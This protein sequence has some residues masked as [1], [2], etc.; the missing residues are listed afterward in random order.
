MKYKLYGY[1][2]DRDDC[3]RTIYR[4]RAEHKNKEQIKEEIEEL[5]EICDKNPRYEYK[6]KIIKKIF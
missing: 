5:K 6:Y 3:C 2:H 1:M 4:K